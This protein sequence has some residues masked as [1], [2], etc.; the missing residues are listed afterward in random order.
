MHNTYFDSL[1]SPYL[2]RYEAALKRLDAIRESGE[3]LD[4]GG[5][6]KS[7]STYLIKMAAHMAQ[8][9]PAFFQERSLED[10]KALNKGFYVEVLEETYPDSFANPEKS[11]AVFGK[12]LGQ[13]M[14]YLYAKIMNVTTYVYEG[15]VFQ[16][17]LLLELAADAYEAFKTGA[18]DEIAGLCQKEA[19]AALEE[20]VRV[21]IMRRY[22]SEM[23]A[24]SDIVKSA[25][26][27]DRR[28]LY[29]YGLYITENEFK[30]ADYMEK[31]PEDTVR[32]MADTYVD[33]FIRGYEVGHK[34]MPLEQKR[35]I[36]IAYP[37]GFERVIRKAIRR[38]EAL[39][40]SPV[41]YADTYISPRPRLICAKSSYQF[42][43][44]HRFDEALYLD[45]AYVDAYLKIFAEMSEK[46]GDEIRTMAGPAIQESFGEKPFA[47]KSKS[48]NL[49]YS[50][51]QTTLKNRMN[52]SMSQIINKYLPGSAY[53]FV[54]ITYPTPEIGDK[55]EAIFDEIIKVNTLSSAEYE[56]IHQFIIDALDLGDRVHLLGMK[57]NRTDVTVK[58]HHLEDPAKQTNFENCTADVNVPVGEVFTS[59]VLTGTNG[60]IHVSEVYLN[61]LKYENLEI[62]FKDGY[63][64]SFTCTN[65]DNEADN[66]KFVH[67]NLIH[68]NK[69]LPLG[70]F[71]IGTNT[72][73]Y[74]MAKKFA[75]ANLLP[76]LIAEKMGPHF[77]IGD[78]CYSWA[79][80]VAVYNPDGKEIVARD[81]EKSI[82]R[83]TDVNQAYTQK[84]TDITIPYD[85]LAL[86]EVI[87]DNGEAVTILKDGRF[88]LA[89]TEALNRPFEE[90]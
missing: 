70:E 27:S 80:D 38:F 14:A 64:E 45:E 15:Q 77:A 49:N 87:K 1:N 33:A 61:N 30:I 2:D 25:D 82:L 34:T 73:A 53:S 23:T 76:I 68:P 10:L 57:P 51:S 16:L 89:G 24:Y 79:E 63:T 46:Y 52:A 67:E 86:I 81:N 41:I 31:L 18:S 72:T 20:K 43:Y 26:L 56:T 42:A 84:H 90:A 40:L 88:V 12:Q 29:R 75:I 22:S 9:G 71:A 78:T 8:L 11:A 65:F 28:Y 58:L 60:T 4:D 50:E 21:M 3:P 35:T 7:A 54:I 47:P 59:P 55:F 13:T 32:L 66:R 69:V 19:S 17:A 85:E 37:V 62:T 48:E 36:N 6:F 74:V 39:G 5:Y 44:D 83:K